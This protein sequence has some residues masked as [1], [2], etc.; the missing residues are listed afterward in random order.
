MKIKEIEGFYLGK[1]CLNFLVSVP[2][3]VKF[4]K[5]SAPGAEIWFEPHRKRAKPRR[6]E[7]PLAKAK[8]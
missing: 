8:E 4:D 7:N 6:T 1:Y 3:I 5:N 2:N